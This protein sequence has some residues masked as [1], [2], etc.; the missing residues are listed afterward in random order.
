[1]SSPC[2]LSS[3]GRLFKFLDFVSQTCIFLLQVF[4]FRVHDS[5]RSLVFVDQRRG[6][7]TRRREKPSIPAE[8]RLS[9]ASHFSCAIFERS[10]LCRSSSPM[11][12]R[13]CISNS[14]LPVQRG[15][16]SISLRVDNAK[17]IDR[18]DLVC[19]VLHLDVL[20]LHLR[21]QSKDALL[22]THHEVLQRTKLTLSVEPVGT[23]RIRSMRVGPIGR[24]SSQG[25]SQISILKFLMSNFLV[26]DRHERTLFGS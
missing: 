1:M 5:H 4:L 10:I 18:P 12:A 7:I 2:T 16:P 3:S 26:A 13:F 25:P 20:L 11:S 6:I 24:R 23:N 21:F 17:P 9:R 8:Q 14:T 19:H 15:S 22:Q